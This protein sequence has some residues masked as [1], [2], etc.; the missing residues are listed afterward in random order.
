MSPLLHPFVQIL[1]QSDQNTV[2][3]AHAPRGVATACA[4]SILFVLV[5]HSFVHSFVCCWRH[6]RPSQKARMGTFVYPFGVMCALTD[7]FFSPLALERPLSP[8]IMTPPPFSL[9]PHYY[10]ILYTTNQPPLNQLTHNTRGPRSPPPYRRL[11]RGA[12]SCRSRGRR[13][14][15]GG[16]GGSRGSA[17]RSTRCRSRAGTDW[18]SPVVWGLT[19]FD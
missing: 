11:R 10:T 9:H 19:G 17:G 4:G 15:R 2:R 12:G 1:L 13:R 3:P 8:I 14:R 18:R 5:V 16:L 7:P 6:R